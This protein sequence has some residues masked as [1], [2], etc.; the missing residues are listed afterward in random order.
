[1]EVQPHAFLVSILNGSVWPISCPGHFTSCQK[2]CHNPLDR[3]GG[4]PRVGLN[5]V[6]KEYFPLPEMEPWFPQL[7]IQ[8]PGHCSRL[9]KLQ[10]SKE[11]LSELPF[12]EVIGKTVDIR[13]VK[14]VS[15]FMWTYWIVVGRNKHICWIY[16]VHEIC[17]IGILIS[18]FLS[19]FPTCCWFDGI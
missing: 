3:R 13:N 9:P 12:E 6:K 10:L 11:I 16:T 14:S 2:S 1:M 17:V 18:L 5:S 15:Q 8:Y 7:S 19:R 4:W